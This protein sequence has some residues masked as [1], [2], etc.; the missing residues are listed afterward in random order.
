VHGSLSPWGRLV[1]LSAMLVVGAAAVLGVW[2]VATGEKRQTLYTVRGSLDGITLDLGDVS[3]DI[4]GAGERPSVV[5]RRVDEVAFGRR[6][7]IERSVNGGILRIRTRCP[8]SVPRSCSSHYRLAVPD[9][10]PVTVRTSSGDV[11]FGR[12]R[13]SARIDTSTGNIDVSSFCG[14]SLQ[15]NTNLGDVQA[16]AICPPDSMTLRS[17]TGTVHAVVP[18]GR[19]RVD[20]DSDSGRRVVQGLSSADDAPFQVQALSGS[21]DVVVEGLR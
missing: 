3:A 21:G 8:S 18:R 9:N 2:W 15:A 7:E 4:V 13:A 1:A 5:V 10:V 6:P 20:A 17:R 14:F 16:S 12:F 19:Y 11:R